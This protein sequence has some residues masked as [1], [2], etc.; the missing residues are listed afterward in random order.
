DTWIAEGRMEGM[1][2]GLSKGR[3]EGMETGLSKGRM[4]GLAEGKLNALAENVRAL[5]ET[6][7]LP[8]EKAMDVLKVSEEDRRK[9]SSIL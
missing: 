3:M 8:K 2:T 5:M 4:E 9:L 7:G 1:E 6:L